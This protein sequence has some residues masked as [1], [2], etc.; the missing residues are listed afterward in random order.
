MSAYMDRKLEN[1]FVLKYLL[2]LKS[3][4][5]EQKQI[6][7]I[8]NRKIEQL[9]KRAYEIPVYRKKF[10]AVGAVP[11]DF[12][13]KED[14]IKFPVLTKSE[15]KEWI[16]A[17]LK[18][19]PE[20][21]QY[22]HVY[23]TSGS[24]GTPLKLCASP[25]ENA[26]FAAN[27]L[28]IAME[29]GV[30]PLLDQ[31]MALKDPAIVAKGKDSFWQKLGIL[32][33]HKVSFLAEGE[34]IAEEINRVKPD[35]LYAH[36]TKLMQ[37]VEYARRQNVKLHHPRAYASI[38]ET[39]TEPSIRLFRKYLGERLF[40]S[41]GSMETGACTFTRAGNI[42]KHIITNDTHVINIVDEKNQLAEQGRMLI[43]NL[44][45]HEF[46]IIN[47]DI[48]DGAEITR[49]NGIEYLTNIRGRMNDWI[50]LED[51]RKYDYHPFYAAT[52]HIEEILSFRVIQNNYHEIELELVADP[53]RKVNK[54]SLEKEITGKLEKVI[55]D[56]HMV[57]HYI[58]KRE[59]EADKTGK[60]RFIINRMKEGNS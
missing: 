34:V 42:R 35:F 41:F 20:K 23:T 24:T 50:V 54:E 46:P 25:R 19:N 57:Y 55:T 37:T 49:R 36:R 18:K 11:E 5:L 45:L 4:D 40:T 27:W 21:Y 26:Y 30:N 59:I 12:H 8:Q 7:R 60:L 33:R 13:C 14:L 53:L 22:Y 38:S 51:G 52:E 44:F 32:R 17:E 10:E 48:G 15:I 58:W 16:T 47:Y 43:T 28:R 6:Y 1:L 9:M 39:L 29:N 2:E 3:H 56:Y 31:T